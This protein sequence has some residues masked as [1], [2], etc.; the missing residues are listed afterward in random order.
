MFNMKLRVLKT[1]LM[2]E[3]N[4]QKLFFFFLST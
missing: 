3:D 2:R 4:V 1:N